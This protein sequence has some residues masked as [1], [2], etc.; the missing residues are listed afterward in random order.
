MKEDYI[1]HSFVN[2]TY[3]PHLHTF[4]L[5]YPVRTS[6][7]IIWVKLLILATSPTTIRT[8][9]IVNK[10]K[11]II[12]LTL[13]QPR[14]SKTSLS[15][16]KSVCNRVK[17]NKNKQMSQNCMSDGLQEKGS[18]MGIKL[19]LAFPTLLWWKRFQKSK[20]GFSSDLPGWVEVSQSN[21]SGRIKIFNF[22]QHS[23][24]WSG[25]RD[26]LSVLSIYETWI[27]QKIKS[28]VS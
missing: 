8:W 16:D 5:E 26:L 24:L 2:I 21:I 22:L 6:N 14:I 19:T 3:K 28:K 1:L 11:P 20:N 4:I 9:N 7:I 27:I 18:N 13:W 25:R 17:K 12:L 15:F 23:S 10:T